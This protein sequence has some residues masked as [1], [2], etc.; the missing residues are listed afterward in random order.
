MSQQKINAALIF[1]RGWLSRA[2]AP[3]GIFPLLS[4]SI[5]SWTW[6]ANETQ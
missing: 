4:V 1:E 2:L 5:L 3:C 6:D